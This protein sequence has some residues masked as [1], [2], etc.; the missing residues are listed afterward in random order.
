ML[1]Y[2]LNLEKV[3]EENRRK[4]ELNR[5]KTLLESKNALNNY[6]EVEWSS[7]NQLQS[8]LEQIE[9]AA[10]EYYETNSK[11]R[12]NKKKSKINSETNLEQNVSEP[13]NPETPV[14]CNETNL[15]QNDVN[16]DLS[17]DN[18]DDL[19][20][21]LVCNKKFKTINSFQNHEKSKKHLINL[22]LYSTNDC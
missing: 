15:E 11:K 19:L 2:K 8:E 16:G 3:V 5:Q 1:Q 7:M 6:V 18:E 20:Y 21:C 12:K 10:N 9:T 22:D 17:D 14:V 13:N 4:S